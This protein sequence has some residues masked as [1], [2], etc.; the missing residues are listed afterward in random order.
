[1]QKTK[2]IDL[3]KRLDKREISKFH[4]FLASPYCN[5]HQ[6]LQQL[7][8]YLL[9]YAPEFE[10]EAL[11]KPKVYAALFGTAPYQELKLNNLISD[12]LQLLNQFLCLQALDQQPVLKQQLLIETLM[13]RDAS[14]QVEHQL[15]RFQRIRE[16][17]PLRNY[18]HFHFTQ[19]YHEQLDQLALGQTRR[20]FSEHLQAQSDQLDLYYF[21][22]KL[23][24]ACDM[25]SR[26]VVI[27]A[28]YECH[29]LDDILRHYEQHQSQLQ[30]IPAL[31]IYYLAL[32]MLRQPAAEPHY[33]ALKEALRQ[34]AGLFPAEELRTLYQYA[35]NYGIK[36]V[37]S[38][39]SHYYREL[40]E[41][42]QVLLD[43]DIIFHHG[44]YLTQWTFKNIVTAGIRLEEFSWT[45]AFIETY[46]KHLP[47]EERTNAQAYSLAALYY[48][49]GTFRPA[50]LQLQDVEFT[51]SSY[52]LGA[53]I[54]QLKCYYE[55]MEIEPFYALVEA[56]KKYLLRNRSISSY[57][58]KAN[59]NMLKLAK[60]V[61]QLKYN[62]ELMTTSAFNQK[63]RRIRQRLSTLT[64]LANKD[65][66]EEIFAQL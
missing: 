50:L 55:L 54:I 57:R 20:K 12:L 60:S 27:Q 44:G 7:G 66:L 53:K 24:I 1:M 15:R 21:A 48:A 11:A 37:N 25:T 16:Q 56:F 6:I 39:K 59:A 36:M 46:Q 9:S 2:L 33:Q 52:H 40:L 58:K 13:T 51:D 41:L 17:H 42:Y 30:N 43:R 3:L 19:R 18:E 23:R 14:Q 34:H 28:D 63:Y 10:H 4:T 31:N 62:R 64:P 5:K 38:G 49:R 61:F 29:F 35:L 65:W 22:N 45:E 8:H 32:Q 47:P 26:N